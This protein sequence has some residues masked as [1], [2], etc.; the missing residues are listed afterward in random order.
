MIRD[1]SKSSYAKTK[2]LLHPS[3]PVSLRYLAFVLLG[4]KI[5]A[6]EHSSVEDAQANMTIYKLVEA[7]WEA[8]IARSTGGCAKQRRKRSENDAT[9]CGM[10]DLALLTND[11]FW[12]AVNCDNN[13]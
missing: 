1:T 5:Q 8:G 10:P 2:A 4:V 3:A 9:S 13:S 6:G 12:E 11:A 7:E